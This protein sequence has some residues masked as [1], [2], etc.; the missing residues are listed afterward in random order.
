MKQAL[1]RTFATSIAFGCAAVAISIVM[2]ALEATG[3]EL[4]AGQPVEDWFTQAAF[5]VIY[6][7][8]AGFLIDSIRW[9]TAVAWAPATER[10]RNRRATKV[11][12]SD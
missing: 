6:A 4:T 8:L 7:L 2:W 1:L 9:L 12:L 3:R 5:L 10:T 11:C